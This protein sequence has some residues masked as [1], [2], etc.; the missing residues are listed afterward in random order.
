[1][2]WYV[3]AVTAVLW[4]TT[5]AGIIIGLLLGRWLW[6]TVPRPSVVVRRRRLNSSERVNQTVTM[7]PRGTTAGA[8]RR[9]RNG[10]GSN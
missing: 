10:D 5:C 8:V 4:L 7:L 1:M 3:V 6:T 2:F 9:R